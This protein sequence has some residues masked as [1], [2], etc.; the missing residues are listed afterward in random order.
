MVVVMCTHFENLSRE[1]QKIQFFLLLCRYKDNVAVEISE[2]VKIEKYG[3]G[4]V[5]LIISAATTT[6]GGRYKAVASSPAGKASCAAELTVLECEYIC[7]IG[8]DGKF[9]NVYP[10][11]FLWILCADVKIISQI[12]KLVQNF[13][14]SNFNFRFQHANK[15]QSL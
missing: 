7:H 15:V 14:K 4:A 3:G 11:V 6:D 13:P 10:P 9:E 12:F 1:N 2:H 5:T 8:M